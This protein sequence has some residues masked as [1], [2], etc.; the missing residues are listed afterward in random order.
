MKPVI[1]TVAG[2]D[3]GGGAGIQ[4]D[5]RAIVANGGFPTTVLTALTAQNL[6]GVTDVHG[7]PPSHVEAQLS[8]VTDGFP[9]SAVKTGMLWSA[10]TIDTVVAGQRRTQCPWVVDPV[11]VATSGARLLQDQAIARYVDGLLPLASL[12]TP[13][14]DEAAVLLGEASIA[15]ADHEDAATTLASRFGVA[16]LVKG[17][18]RRGDLIDVLAEGG[19]VH[20]FAGVR[21]PVNTHGSGCALASAIAAHLG[22]GAGLVAA[23]QAGLAYIQRAAASPLRL[24]E[25]VSVLGLDVC[26]PG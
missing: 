16:F 24:R 9:V 25:E 21:Y 7:V 12:V 19:R 18:H 13:N 26:E 22:A 8:A 17:G 10:E 6:D 14:L 11:M 3:S 2:S 1:M 20:R 5:L 15:D 23:T 4:A